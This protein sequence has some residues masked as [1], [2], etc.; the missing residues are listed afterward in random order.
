MANVTAPITKKCGF[1]VKINPRI[2]MTITKRLIAFNLA[3]NV[4]EGNGHICK[5]ESLL[6]NIVGSFDQNGVV[7]IYTIY[8]SYKILFL[9]LLLLFSICICI[10]IRICYRIRICRLSSS[11]SSFYLFSSAKDFNDFFFR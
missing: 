5:I 7:I 3:S 4:R 1:I 2:D 8:F 6:N 10:R 9:T 11:R